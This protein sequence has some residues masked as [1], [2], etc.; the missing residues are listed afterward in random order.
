MQTYKFYCIFVSVEIKSKRCKFYLDMTKN[1]FI[2]SLK[3]MTL[4]GAF[5]LSAC[6]P[7]EKAEPLSFSHIN[8]NEQVK[9]AS[10]EDSPSC[11]IKMDYLY[12]SQPADSITS[13][14][15]QRINRTVLGEAFEALTPE[16][17][18]DSFVNQYIRNYKEEV[19]T[20][21]EEEL[22]QG[23]SPKEIPHW[24][25]YAHEV[26]SEMTQ[27]SPHLLNYRAAVYSYQGGAHPN[28]WEHWLCFD[29]ATGKQILVDRIFKKDSKDGLIKLIQR[30]LVK[31]MA[32]IFPEK[33]IA[34]VEDLKRLA[35]PCFDHLF[36][37]D[38]FQLTNDSIKFLYN[39][40]DVAPY[41]F[42]KFIVS[43]SRQELEPF[44]IQ[45]NK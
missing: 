24:F 13:L 43:L 29:P 37:S 19:K 44:M 17:A 27:V 2:C 39:K 30:E 18:V 23:N 34:S 14:M 21:Y 33:K 40:Y 31:R 26:K 16:A 36:V 28:E 6:A 22:K 4:M 11:D 45:E 35:L 41:V 38:N 8:K 20:Y 10:G 42:G 32:E 9:L 7:V 1:Q 15:N 3:G 12:I 25:N 5:C